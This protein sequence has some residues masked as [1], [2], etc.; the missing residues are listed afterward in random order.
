MGASGAEP[1]PVR[2]AASQAAIQSRLLFLRSTIA[3]HDHAY[4]VLDAPTIPDAEYD[5]LMRELRDIE[6][7]HPGLVAPDSP[8]QRVGGAPLAGFA[9]VQHSVPMLSLDN[10]M[11]DTDLADFD[12]RVRER[13]EVDAVE[14]NAEPKIDGLAISL[15]YEDGLL[16]RAATRGDGERGEDVTANV[17][18]VRAI[19][20]RLLGAD[21]PPLLEVR[22]EVYMPRRGL[23]GLNARL[24]KAGEKTFANPRNAAAGSLR[25]LDSRITATRPL[26]F[27][28]YGWGA[29]EGL[30]MPAQHS[31]MLALLR[32]FGLPVNSLN[33]VVQGAAGAQ[34]Y[35]AKILSLRAALDYDI[36][37]AVFKVNR[38]ADQQAL[39]FVSRAPRWAVAFKFPPEEE[40]TTLLGVDWQVGRTGALTPVARLAP[41][42]VGGVVV[43]NASLHNM[44]MIRQKDVRI[45]DTVIVRRAGDVIPEIVGSVL[46]RRPPDAPEIMAPAA[47]PVCGSH[48]EQIEGE[49]VARCSGGLY[50][51]AQ[52]R[53][54]IRHFAA[55]RAMDIDGLGEKIIAQL[56]EAGLVKRL[57]DL[58]YLQFSDVAALERMGEKSAHNLLDALEKSKS[59]TLARFLFAL[60]IPEVGETTAQALAKHFGSLDALREA[61]EADLATAQSERK[62]D[63]YPSLQAVPDVGLTI[64]AHIAGFFAE[65]HNREVIARLLAAGIGWDVP[66]QVAAAQPLAGKTYV[67]TGTL[68]GMTREEAKAALEALG[69]KVSESVSKKT[70]ALIAGEAAGSKLAK[71]QALGLP[72]LDTEALRELLAAN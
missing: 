11:G 44:D 9:G 37:G 39:G 20:L 22:G 43:S 50:C 48:V 52:R 14:Y 24:E 23:A 40:L 25:Q 8:T 5:R 18:T 10:A 28:A 36:D 30:S 32:D 3:A 47:C 13:L 61:A 27:F 19:P 29:I 72:V 33:A 46:A 34:K 7:A 6:T 38:L 59:T 65:A 2:C 56:D 1:H 45:G 70:T 60:G 55:R 4:Y 41:V 12:R 68:D 66:V 17:R 51:P 53:E 62:K 15:R 31:D 54:A 26:S 63:R 42:H 16:V 35:A 49:A 21:V 69:A 64:A 57:D 71:A 58:Y 67:I